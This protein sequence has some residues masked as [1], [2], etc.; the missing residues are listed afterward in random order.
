MQQKHNDSIKET[1]YQTMFMLEWLEG[2]ISRQKS[3]LLYFERMKI[4][5][6]G[7]FT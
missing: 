5:C 1:I 2:K 3:F 7:K 6:Y 4:M